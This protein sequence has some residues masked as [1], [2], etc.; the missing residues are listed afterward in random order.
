[1][2]INRLMSELAALTYKSDTSSYSFDVI[3]RADLPRV[4]QVIRQFHLDN[5][6]E[7]F[8]ELKA[9]CYAYEKIIANSN[10]APMLIKEKD[11]DFKGINGCD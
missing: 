4:E 9:K 11:D 1:M 5:H 6:D 3:H 7:Q 10:F 8:G 2:N